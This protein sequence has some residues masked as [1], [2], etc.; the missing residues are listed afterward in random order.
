MSALD[1]EGK[2]TGT[3]ES[4]DDSDAIHPTNKAWLHEW[5]RDM[6]LSDLSTATI[7]KRMAHMKVVAEHLEQTPFTDL[8]KAD[9]KDLVEWLQSRDTAESTVEGYK[10]IIRFFWKWLYDHEA[11]E[12]DDRN[13]YPVIVDWISPNYHASNNTLPKDLLT[14]EEVDEQIEAAYNPRDKAFI[15]LLYETG[16]RI[17]ELI[18]LTVGDIEDR[19]HGRKIVIDGKTG[20][21]RLPLNESVPYLN[22]WLNVHPTGN[23]EDPLWCQLRSP[24]PLSYEY[25]RQ[26]ILQKCGDRVGI[27]KPVNPH[28]YRH[29]RATELANVFTEAQLCEW[30]GWVQGSDIPAK[31]VHTSGRDID[32]AY[33]EL[34]GKA[35]TSGTTAESSTRECPRCDEINRKNAKWCDQCGMD[36]SQEQAEPEPT[37]PAEQVAAI[38]DEHPELLEEFYMAT[39]ERT[40]DVLIPDSDDSGESYKPRVRQWLEQEMDF[41]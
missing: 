2:V 18:D 5:Q 32:Q 40:A 4:I 17:G 16:A 1:F 23:K 33:D 34:H 31:Y 26:K 25:I 37:D 12:W 19:E 13:D 6:S 38:F 28:H 29:S 14:K 10:K 21:R 7:Q 30:F 27:E 8:T 39:L 20:P 9:V 11:I 15:A 36:L 3:M 24:E 22:N 35:D 41:E